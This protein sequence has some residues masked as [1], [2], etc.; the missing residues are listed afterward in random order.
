M[1]EPNRFVPEYIQTEPWPIGRHVF[2]IAEIGINHN[3]DLEIAKALIDMAKKADCDAVKFQKRTIDIVYAKEFLDS[4][5][6]SPWGS[7][8]RAQKEA[9]EFG[10]DEYDEIDRYCKEKGIAWFASAWD[11]PSQHFLRQYNLAYNKIASA[12]ITH[13]EL[14]EEVAG[15]K[16]LTF[17]S[18]GMSTYEQ[19]DQAVAVFERHQCPYVLMHCVSNYPANEQELNLR[20]MVELWRRYKCPVGYSGHEVTMIPSVLAAMMGA[21]AVERHITLDRAMYGSDQAA[22]LEKR[23][24]ELL[25]SYIRTIPRVMGDGIKRVTTAEEANAKKL[26][27]W[28]SHF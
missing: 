10:K 22:S 2:V 15:E 12:M 16:R 23:G 28:K 3:G 7:T 27:Y 1:T 21:V 18:T 20:C 5:R 4:P 8:Q 6:E 17:I 26:R 14:L 13:R 24:L 25:T 19:I 9:L 11:V